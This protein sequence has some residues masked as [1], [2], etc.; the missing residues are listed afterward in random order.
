MRYSHNIHS[1]QSSG[2]YDAKKGLIR[3]EY[4]GIHPTV[5]RAR[6]HINTCRLRTGR[7]G[8]DL[9]TIRIDFPSHRPCGPSRKLPRRTLLSRNTA[10]KSVGIF[11]LYGKII[12]LRSKG[13][14][15]LVG[16]VSIDVI[17]NSIILHVSVPSAIRSIEFVLYGSLTATWQH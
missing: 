3:E 13:S 1:K 15:G 14:P 17:Q 7:Q 4:R 5:D 11:S 10:Y 16:T 9:L 6:A 12:K 2:W 8:T